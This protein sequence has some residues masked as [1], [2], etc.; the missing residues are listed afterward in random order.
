MIDTSGTGC[1]YALEMRRENQ[2]KPLPLVGSLSKV[3]LFEC[4]HQPTLPTHYQWY[5]HH[6]FTQN[7][8]LGIFNSYSALSMGQQRL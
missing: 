6:K 8:R 7:T 2:Q 4:M 3:L 5:S 1:C